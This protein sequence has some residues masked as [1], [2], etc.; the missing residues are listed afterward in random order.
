M[1]I[2]NRPAIYTQV[3]YN[4]MGLPCHNDLSHYSC[5]MPDGDF[6]ICKNKHLLF[7]FLRSWLDVCP[8]SMHEYALASFRSVLFCSVLFSVENCKIKTN[9]ESTVNTGLFSNFQAETSY[10][11]F[12]PSCQQPTKSLDRVRP[13]SLAANWTAAVL[14]STVP[15]VPARH[16]LMIGPIV[17]DQDQIKL[18]NNTAWFLNTQ[19]SIKYK[20]YRS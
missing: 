13:R 17:W 5:P 7:S 4:S 19:S 2:T 8:R 3:H 11:L 9:E 15:Q 20:I 16:G 10:F 12:L 18:I 14:S 6:R 1:Q